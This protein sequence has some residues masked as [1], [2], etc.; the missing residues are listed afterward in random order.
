MMEIMAMETGIMVTATMGVM[1]TGIMVVE[2]ATA[3]GMV[4]V[5]IMGAAMGMA[6][7]MVVEMATAVGMAAGITA[8]ETVMVA[9]IMT[10]AMAATKAV[11]RVAEKTRRVVKRNELIHE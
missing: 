2:M 8:V 3:V 1:V 9:G 10:P 6:A 4:M 5:G 11:I 7:A